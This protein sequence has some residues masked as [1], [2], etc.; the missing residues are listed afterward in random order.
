MKANNMTFSEW[1]TTGLYIGVGANGQKADWRSN[2]TWAGGM[3]HSGVISVSTGFNSGFEIWDDTINK[4]MVS[5][6]AK[7]KY[8]SGGEALSA[9][10][11]KG[12]HVRVHCFNTVDG[13]DGTWSRICLSFFGD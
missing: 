9:M 8:G 1:K 3:P 12:H 11:V 13:G 4:V 7:G 2:Q 10:F 6:S 5:V